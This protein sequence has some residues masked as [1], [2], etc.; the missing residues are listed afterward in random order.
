MKK[1]NVFTKSTEGIIIR[2]SQSGDHALV[3]DTLTLEDKK[4]S[5][6]FASAKKNTGIFEIFDICS[7]EFT[8]SD[9]SLK[10]LKDFNFI[11][12]PKNLRKDFTKF[13]AT[14]TLFEVFDL[15]IKEDDVT[16]GTYKLLK[17]AILKIEEE[18][19]NLKILKILYDTLFSLLSVLG[20]ENKLLKKPASK[21]NLLNLLEKIER[22]LERKLKST[23]ALK[24]LLPTKRK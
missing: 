21:N 5:L 23:Q 13:C 15:L 8:D 22:I 19:E 24:E 16:C 4:I 6:Y 14:T 7:L 1:N 2:C 17:S 10:K 11:L 18:Q 20:F 12:S 9:S 3:F